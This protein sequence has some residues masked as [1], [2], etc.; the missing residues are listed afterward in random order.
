MNMRFHAPSLSVAGTVPWLLFHNCCC[1]GMPEHILGKVSNRIPPRFGGASPNDVFLMV[2]A[3]ASD[4]TLCQ[5]PLV[6]W[7][8]RTA[9]ECMSSLQ[10]IAL[11]RVPGYLAAMLPEVM[12]CQGLAT[13][14]D[15]ERKETLLEIVEFLRESYSIYGRAIHYLE[16]LAGV[17]AM[18]RAP[19]GRIEFLLVPQAGVQRGAIAL[20]NPEPHTL[21]TM[22]VTFHRYH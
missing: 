16:Q 19:A 2:K 17:R 11:N 5:P 13:H 10:D 12:P 6:V 15:Q 1:S 9:D 20:G 21:H 22:K 8:G 14:L 4:S 18:H 3:F 7:P